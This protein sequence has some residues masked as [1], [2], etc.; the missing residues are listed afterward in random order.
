LSFGEAIKAFGEPTYVL[1]FSTCEWLHIALFYPDDGLYLKYFD[2]RW[3]S[4]LRSGSPTELTP[5]QSVDEVI[6]YDPALFADMIKRPLGVSSLR[7]EHDEILR[8]MQPWEGF[9]EIQDFSTC[10]PRP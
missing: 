2:P 3:R 9:G 6:F 8:I 10:R 5:E 7:Y 1:P 4:P